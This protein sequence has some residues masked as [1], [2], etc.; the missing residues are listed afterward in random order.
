M[1]S[2]EASVRKM[3]PDIFA[4]MIPRWGKYC[5]P[6]W[7]DGE[8]NPGI[9]PERILNGSV[10]QI[11]WPDG[12]LRDSELDLACKDHD[13][14]Y[15]LAKGMPNEATLVARADI[16][17]VERVTGIYSSLSPEEKSYAA[18]AVPTFIVKIVAVDGFSVLGENIKSKISDF[19]D[20]LFKDSTPTDPFFMIYRS[21]VTHSITGDSEG[22]VVVDRSDGKQDFRV[23]IDL[24]LDD[25]EISQKHIDRA[26]EIFEETVVHV[27]V[28]SAIAEVT[29]MTDGVEDLK[30]VIV[31]P[32]TQEKLD[33]FS[34]LGSLALDL[35][36]LHDAGPAVPG[37]AEAAMHE[38]FG[39]LDVPLEFNQI[40]DFSLWFDETNPILIEPYQWDG[41]DASLENFW[42]HGT[43]QTLAA[44]DLG[45]VIEEVDWR[46]DF[47]S[48]DW[49]QPDLD[50][51]YSGNEQSPDYYFPEPV[52]YSDSQN[53]S[54]FGDGF[55]GDSALTSGSGSGSADPF[56]SFI[57]PLVLKLG[58]GAVHTT[59]RSGSSVRFDM[60]GDGHKEKTGWITAD[61]AFLVRDKNKNGKVDG[62]SEMFSEK[63]S[64][65]ASTGF[66]ALAELDTQPNG[67]IDKYD[68]QFSELR[69]WT[70]INANGVTDSSELHKLSKFGIKSIDLGSI[71]LRNQYDNGNMV[72]GTA[73]YTSDRNGVVYTGEV[74]EVLFNF[75]EHA[76]VANVYLSDQ[77][78]AVR[79]ADGKVIEVLS[80]AGAQKVNA[81]L[82][83][84]NVL[85]GEA[86]DVLNAG[87][88]G[89]SLLIGNGGAILNGNGGAVHFIVNGSLN[90]VNTGM[91]TSVIDVHGDG[92]TINAAK[93]EVVL[94][95]D[96]SRN[97]ISIGSNA[98][99]DLGGT[100]NT[101]TAAAK[102]EDNEIEVTGKGHVVNAS[103]ASI[104]VNPHTV[105]T[106][107]GKDNDI[108]MEGDATLA[109]KA[110]GGTLIVT[111]DDNVA[112]LTGA[113]VGVSD[114]ELTLTG[115][116]HQVVLAG[117]ASV[118]MTSSAK[119]S[120]I[121][122]FGKDN[123]L[124]AN[125]A[126]I[127]VAKGAELDL[128]GTGDK[129]TLTGNDTLDADGSA[130]VIDVYGSRNKVQIDL[131]TVYERG[132][133]D[134]TLS[135]AGNTLKVTKDNS[136][137]VP[138]EQIILGYA[139]RTLQEAWSKYEQAA[140]TGFDAAGNVQAGS[141]VVVELTGVNAASAGLLA[142]VV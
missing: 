122:V 69:L 85:I 119:T 83:G 101:L 87:N 28:E 103:D 53:P 33:Q 141:T 89:Q 31:G 118:V 46:P 50:P 75:G 16:A 63:T 6:S 139:G 40:D 61:H 82:S 23:K 32:L 43:D 42:Y 125:K 91:G 92:N 13:Y 102:S 78:T 76:P 62:I 116:K 140:D 132:L 64:P 108:T 120:I 88:A 73:S 25:A 112:S 45:N 131:S 129:V 71:V 99:V 48:D 44:Y 5:G 29:H 18:L 124:T 60:D 96:G 136:A 117:E 54:G 110:T 109:G 97:M 68:K 93:G 135:G 105:V 104:A 127:Y 70:D 107:N 72:L 138:W 113:F 95:V 142:P 41:I 12:E 128:A 47:W 3:T 106:L 134:L 81:S 8:A 24:A 98:E 20:D 15:A 37:T 34:E 86:G 4:S 67:R 123:E 38:L 80:D 1:H 52:Y 90:I 39:V 79:T 2:N 27:D 19:F 36:A 21:G 126:T 130:H 84:V 56:H 7:S 94:D 35:P 17:F 49:S 10:Q 55:F 26:G 111:G 137:E 51:W 121:N 11:R 22:Y 77:A 9:G 133:A 114:G 14:A 59:N 65:T 115:L 57:D 74:A 66:G 100:A 30:G 58:K